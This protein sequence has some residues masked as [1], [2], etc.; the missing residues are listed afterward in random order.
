MTERHRK[1]KE[2][3]SRMRVMGM[4]MKKPAKWDT[5]EYLESEA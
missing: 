4:K 2:A 1:S 5:S 3:E